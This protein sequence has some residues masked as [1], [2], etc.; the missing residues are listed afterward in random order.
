MYTK[1][2]ID[3]SYI[4]VDN[5]AKFIKK[6]NQMIK[7]SE[8]QQF[9]AIA[10]RYLLDSHFPLS[11]EDLESI[12]VADFG[13]SNV[14][15]EGAQILTLYATERTSCKLIVLL[16]NQI[17]PEHWHPPVEDD[18]GKEEILRGYYGNVLY[19]EEGDNNI[20]NSQVPNS[21]KK[22]YTARSRID[23]LPGKQVIIPSG[24]KHWMKGG[25]EGGI[26]ISFST[27]VRDALD[28]FNDPNIERIT[29]F[30]KD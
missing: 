16:P 12:A 1:L 21:K 29:K 2:V 20:D 4:P 13:M 3:F 11:K 5:E 10:Q 17:L 14:L 24:K 7:R 28:Q 22:Y 27:C 26:V 23:L 19:F 8:E 9:K 15:F 18:P 30:I 6:E 25:R